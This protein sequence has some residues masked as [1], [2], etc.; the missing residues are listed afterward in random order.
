M[1][2]CMGSM[3]ICE[4]FHM[5]FFNCIYFC[6]YGVLPTCMF[7]NCLCARCL[8]RPEEDVD[9]PGTGVADSCEPLCWC[10]ELNPDPLLED[11]VL[12]ISGA[13]FCDMKETGQG[14][15]KGI[16]TGELGT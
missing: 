5:F 1:P 14:G 16:G 15:N 3:Q 11:P 6:V 13:F 12:L 7:V 2:M 9:S 4:P 10:W 8:W